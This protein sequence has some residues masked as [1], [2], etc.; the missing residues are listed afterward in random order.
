MVEVKGGPI[1]GKQEKQSGSAG[2]IQ[3]KLFIWKYEKANKSGK[4]SKYY[5]NV[6]SKSFTIEIAQTHP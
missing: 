3:P 5:H 1:L 2:C 4:K 6:S